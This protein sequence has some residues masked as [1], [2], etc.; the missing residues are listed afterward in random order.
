M[1]R[2]GTPYRQT[3]GNSRTL[4]GLRH[5]YATDPLKARPYASSRIY[6]KGGMDPSF[7]RALVIPTL[8]NEPIQLV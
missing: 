8:G 4:I 7:K 5:R 1:P 2:E 3:A 6:P